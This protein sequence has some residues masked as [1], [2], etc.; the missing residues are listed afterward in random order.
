MSHQQP[1]Q[2]PDP[3][4][5][6]APLPQHTIAARPS[7][8]DPANFA[9]WDW[10]AV[11]TLGTLLPAN[12]RHTIQQSTE[13]RICADPDRF[14]L[15][16]DCED[17]HIW[18]T[19]TQRN[20]PIYDEEVVELFIAPGTETPTTYYEFEFSPNGT[21][22]DLIAHSPHGDRR[23]MSIDAGWDCPDIWWHAQRNDAESHWS[24]STSIP[25][26]SLA[27]DITHP[28]VWRANF[29]RIE[30]PKNSPPE[31]SC[32]SPTLADPPDFHRAARFGTLH[33]SP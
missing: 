9:D 30:R 17:P 23:E 21:L 25:W 2:Q 31:F 22:L 10:Q 28:S 19:Y 27:P 33:F 11:P 20:D 24:L 26:T 15:R 29:Y 12:P 16:F 4:P 6:P 32:W 13:V 14:F 5:A 7:V 3:A 8:L 18:G 1:D